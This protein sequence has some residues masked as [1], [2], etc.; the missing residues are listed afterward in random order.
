MKLAIFDIDG[1]LTETNEVDDKC[2]VRAFAAS[3]Q[4]TDIETDWTKYTH[5]TDSGLVSEIFNQRLGRSPNEE[6]F[7]AFKNR[8]IENLNEY[9]SKDE[10]LF[11]EVSNAKA[12]LEKLKLEKDWTIALA[13]GC[14]YDSA[15][16]KLE[17]AKIDVK[18]FPIGTAD[19][20]ISR[21]KILQT[22][23]EKSLEKYGLKKFEKIVSIG[24]GI[25]DV[26]TAKN[27]SLDFIG[28]ASGKRAEVLREEGANYIIKD[29]TDYE[30]FLAYLNK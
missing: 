3:H 17:K 26:R 13:T 20:A 4:I 18:D 27:L 25:W 30:N 8:F 14:F 6:D 28:I 5:V 16:L 9:T 29:F 23:I 22:A 24:D 21:E 19:D 2:F 7:L 12:M 15:K 1:T 11:A 10:T